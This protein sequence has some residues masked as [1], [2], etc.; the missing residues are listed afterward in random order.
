VARLVADFVEPAK[1]KAYYELGDGRR[2]LSLAVGWLR[3]KVDIAAAGTG[4][5]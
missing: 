3:S 2:G 1:S 5:G 4:S